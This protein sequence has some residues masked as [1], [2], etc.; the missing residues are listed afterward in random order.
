MITNMNIRAISKNPVE[1]NGISYFNQ[2]GL[3]HNIYMSVGQESLHGSECYI[4]CLYALDNR[5]ISLWWRRKPPPAPPHEYLDMY[6]SS[7]H[8]KWEVYKFKV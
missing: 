1:C 3:T 8:A 4:L 6:N 2:G 5:F 7:S